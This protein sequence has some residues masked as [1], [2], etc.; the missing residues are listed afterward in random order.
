[1]FELRKESLSE[2]REEWQDASKVQLSGKVLVTGEKRGDKVAVL[3]SRQAATTV[4]AAYAGI[5]SCIS[6]SD[7]GPEGKVLRTVPAFVQPA[8]VILS[9]GRQNQG[10]A[11][12]LR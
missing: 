4:P 1:M 12:V 3:K 10:P 9:E 2:K 7:G 6:G 11:G 8:A 5:C